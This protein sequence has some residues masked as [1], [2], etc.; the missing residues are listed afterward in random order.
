MP[1]WRQGT[2]E[3]EGSPEVKKEY[4]ADKGIPYRCGGSMILERR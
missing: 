4:V 3:G 2:G 1:S